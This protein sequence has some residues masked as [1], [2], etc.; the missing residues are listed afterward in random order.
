M[1]L[2]A[3]LDPTNEGFSDGGVHTARTDDPEVGADG[4]QGAECGVDRVADKVS[5]ASAIVG[6]IARISSFNRSPRITERI[7]DLRTALTPWQ[8]SR[9]V[10]KLDD[11][12][13][14][15]RLT[16]SSSTNK[17]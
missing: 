7:A 1:R 12:L 4:G 15:Y 10:R 3:W 13:A 16:G 17:S 2:R 14:H 9:A 5:D 11:F 6:D 8:R